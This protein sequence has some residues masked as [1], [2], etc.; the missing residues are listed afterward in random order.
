MVRIPVDLEILQVLYRNLDNLEKILDKLSR[1]EAE[2]LVY[3]VTCVHELIST[4]LDD[5][6]ATQELPTGDDH[7][8]D[9]KSFCLSLPL[10]RIQAL[11]TN[12]LKE[13]KENRIYYVKSSGNSTYEDEG[14]LLY[15]LER[16]MERKHD[17]DCGQFFPQQRAK[18]FLDYYKDFLGNV[19][20]PLTKNYMPYQK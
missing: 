15:W 5:L 17:F 20:I 19:T 6:E 3:M 9:F 18:E 11:I 14:Y 7:F 13:L 8:L 10:D 1:D 2:Y 4:S 12:P 16:Y